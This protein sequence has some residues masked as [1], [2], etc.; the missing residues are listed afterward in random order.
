[1]ISILSQISSSQEEALCRGVLL[2]YK[3]AFYGYAPGKRSVI[4]SGDGP[5]ACDKFSAEQAPSK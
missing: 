5:S 3:S 2:F 4:S 1:M